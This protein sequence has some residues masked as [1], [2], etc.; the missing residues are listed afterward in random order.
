MSYEEDVAFLERHCKE[1]EVDYGI[2]KMIYDEWFPLLT[3]A[4][5]LLGEN[6]D[7]EFV[8][9]WDKH[10]YV[11][12]IQY[13]NSGERLKHRRKTPEPVKEELEAYQK[14][15]A[16]FHK[17]TVS[18]NDDYTSDFSLNTYD[19]KGQK[20]VEQNLSFRDILDDLSRW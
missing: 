3:Q 14:V 10:Q 16:F 7:K 18:G 20:L 19:A 1:L 15:S 8:L 11:G 6:F 13:D 5:E 12:S 2:T 4:H 17:I 9:N